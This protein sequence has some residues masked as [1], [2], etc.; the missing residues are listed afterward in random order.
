DVDD[1]QF[2]WQ[3]DLTMPSLALRGTSSIATSQGAAFVGTP[4]GKVL[5]LFGDNGAPIWEAQIA[6]ATGSN[7]LQRVVDVD[8]KPL[9][10]GNNLYAISF[11]GALAS[12]ELRSGRV[13]WNRTYSSFS[14]PISEGLDLYFSDASS[15]VYA[16]DRRNGLEKW[17]NRELEGRK[18]TEPQVIGRYIVVGDYEGYLHVMERSSGQLVGQFLVDKSG[19]YTQPVRDGNTLYLQSRDGDVTAVTI[20]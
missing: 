11:N 13:L 3:A 14:S 1:G 6:E 17:A 4:D 16:I 2:Q 18:L 5:A 10:I 19:L 20:P 12:I 7:E 9:V 15:V 8:A